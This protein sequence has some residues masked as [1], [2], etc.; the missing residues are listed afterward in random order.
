[1]KYTVELLKAL[2]DETRLRILQLLS[3]AE[4]TVSDLEQILNLPQSRISTQ[5]A[6]LRACLPLSERREGRR[7]WLSLVADG[8]VADLLKL[9]EP[10]L[11]DSRAFQLDR[12]TLASF[13]RKRREAERDQ[14]QA[15]RRGVGRL[16]GRSWESLARG[17]LRLV[18]ARR[19]LDVGVGEGEMT[20]LFASFAEELH[21]VDRDPEALVKL[22]Q[23][24]RRRGVEGIR[25]REGDA[26]A[27][28]LADRSVDLVVMS[29]LLHLLDEPERAVVEA[30][31]VLAPGGRV[32]IFDLAAHDEVWARE[33]L[34]H[35]RLGFQPAELVRFG[36][37]AGL[38]DM[39]A[40]PVARDPEP[41]RFVSI[42]ATG[43]KP[44]EDERSPR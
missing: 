12:Q 24:A 41:P 32:L 5:I 29:Q 11:R 13:L 33:Q 10:S 25:C 30:A 28:P 1:M 14:E 27:L 16:P 7:S 34:G 2:G 6:K 36:R 8:E 18:P 17:L 26:G 31:R 21:A 9:L 15:G 44:D 35:H 19:V 23:K 20:L 40:Y 43:R 38:V 37:E 3:L 4:L 42:L 22:E 39:E